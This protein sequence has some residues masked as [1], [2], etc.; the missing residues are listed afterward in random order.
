MPTYL[1]YGP[2]TFA[3]TQK[4]REIV[5]RYIDKSGALNLGQVEGSQLTIEHWRDLILSVPLLATTR[6][7]VALNVLSDAPPPIKKYIEG[8]LNSLPSDTIAV[9]HETKS[10]DERQSLFKKLRLP[11]TSQRFNDWTPSE[12]RNWLK[13]YTQKLGGQI[14]PPAQDGLIKQIGQDPWLAAQELQK[15]VGFDRQ[16][17]S[18]SITDLGVKNSQITVFAIMDAIRDRN[19]TQFLAVSD[20]LLRAGQA[21]QYLLSLIGASLRQIAK[22]LLATG[23]SPPLR[24]P[25]FLIHKIRQ[26][27]R[28]SRSDLVDAYQTLVELDADIKTGMID[29][30]VA[31]DMFAIRSLTKIQNPPVKY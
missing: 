3:S 25:P 19:L 18:Q 21:P 24:L 11:K 15:L 5:A 30:K 9:F 17:T 13:E 2:N 31:L 4:R 12:F 14:D 1:L 27:N 20:E 28:W 29:E 23:Q 22:V 7:V 10:F 26:Q 8:N 16:I 6:L